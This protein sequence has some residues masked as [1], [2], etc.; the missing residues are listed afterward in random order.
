MGFLK[1]LYQTQGTARKATLLQRL[2]LKKIKVGNHMKD[3]LNNFCDNIYKIDQMNVN[4]D[5]L[6]IMM[7]Y[8]LPTT[9]KFENHP[10]SYSEKWKNL[11]NAQMQD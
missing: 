10:N 3:H 2:I 11:H 6:S 7:L 8:S 5:F 9:N 4:E 1:K